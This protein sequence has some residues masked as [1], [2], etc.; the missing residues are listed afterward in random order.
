MT[1]YFIDTG[2]L[3]ALEL[4]DDQHHAAAVAAWRDVR[5]RRSTF[6]STAYVLD[7]VVTFFNTRGHHAKAVQIGEALLASR[8]ARLVQVDQALFEAGWREFVRRPDKRYSL[9]DCVSF[10]LMK[11]LKIKHALAFDRHFTQA[12]FERVPK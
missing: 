7:E 1:T 4:A 6:V 2:F 10:I 12:G 3:I 5:R 9:T 11:Q 8:I